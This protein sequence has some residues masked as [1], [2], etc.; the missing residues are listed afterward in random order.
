[1]DDQIL[2]NT[3]NQILSRNRI[4][5]SPEERAFLLTA[6]N[7]PTALK[8]LA[9]DAFNRG[10]SK[11]AVYFATKA[12]Q[13]FPNAET[14]ENLISC[15]VQAKQVKAA[16]DLC[17]KSS[18]K[19][20]AMRQAS[21]LSE[22]FARSGSL[23]QSKIWGLKALGL[24]D[25]AA[26]TLDKLPPVKLHTFNSATPA[27]NVISFSLFGSN[28]KYAQGALRNAMI[29]RHL[30]PDWTTRFYV[31]DSISPQI[32][33]ALGREGAQL[34]RVGGLPADRFGTFWRFL[35][36]DDPEVDFY[37]VRDC[38]SILNIKERAAVDQW[39]SSKK[40]FH[41][42]RDGPS[43]SEL[44]LAGMWG[45][46]R[47]N[48]GKMTNRVIAFDK[49]VASLRNSRILDQQFLREVVWPIMRGRV[50]VHDSIFGYGKTHEF[51]PAFSLER[52]THIGDD[53]T[54]PL[55]AGA[56]AQG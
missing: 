14:E 50:C 2:K 44:V 11:D 45:A 3:L 46:H 30:Y 18:T 51:D 25:K 43:Q 23:E 39:L 6:T 28:P 19:L 12:Y 52:G 15:L 42:M 27:R 13:S 55:S 22:L 47:G 37:I 35:V 20:G 40:P 21:L 24:K 56:R 1:M 4:E 26:G 33:K 5:L 49:T 16:I 7:H 31:D 10:S 38:D 36:E 8:L 17:S 34:R 41:L 48:I 9:G 53:M 54:G 32:T 29:A